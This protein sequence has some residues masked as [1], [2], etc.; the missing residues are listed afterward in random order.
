MSGKYD[1]RTYVISSIQAIQSEKNA[2][3]YDLDPSKGEP[4]RK[5]ILGLEKF[6]EINDGELKLLTMHGMDASERDLNPYFFQDRF[7]GKIMTPKERDYMLNKNCIISDIIVPPQNVDP[8]TSKDRYVQSD[9]TMIF[10]HPKQRFK[11]VAAGNAK[12]PKILATTG[13]CTHPNYNETNSKGDTAKK[14][15]KY[16]AVVAEIIDDASYNIRH[17]PAFKNGKFIDLGMMYNGNEVVQERVKCEALV[18]GDIHLGD[19]D[20]QTIEANYEMIDFFKPR[21]LFLHDLVNGHSVNPHERD[22]LVTRA[23]AFEEGRLSIEAELKAINTELNR[24]AK[25][26]KD[27]DVNVVFSNHDFFVDRYIESGRFIHEPWNAKLAGKLWSAMLEGKNP[28]E[29]GIK[30]MG[31]VP[32]NV[33]FL[34]L[35][36]DIK[37]QGWQLASHGH[38]GI[39]GGKGSIQSREVGFGKSIT[40][41]T[42]A[43]EMIRNTIVVGTSTRLDLKYTEGSMSRWLAANAVLYEGGLTQ[44][45]PIIRGKWKMKR[46]PKQKIYLPPAVSFEKKDE[47]ANILEDIVKDVDD[48]SEPE[49]KLA[50]NYPE[51]IDLESALI[52][53]KGKIRNAAN[54]L[55]IHRN[56]LY[57]LLGRYNIDNDSIRKEAKEKEKIE[58]LDALE[59]TNWSIPTAAELL[60]LKPQTFRSRTEKHSI[61]L[62]TKC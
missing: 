47:P 10:A 58:I 2:K 60:N 44:L 46:D 61:E 59:K 21:R 6:C 4:N 15:H 16:G 24:I 35:R 31:P 27:G 55:G 14:D 11:T 34:T 33:R 42:H 25:M 26:M 40:G 50:K 43:P 36:D 20:P 12:L 5:L 19:H 62:K 52:Q 22:N 13:A 30:M 49:N 38:K 18:L 54:Q 56:V 41:H 51:R 32:S 9:Q 1:H 3:K 37:L 48:L 39:S 28:S 8:S 57:S 23:V 53:N 17:I 29:E 7:Q 45:L